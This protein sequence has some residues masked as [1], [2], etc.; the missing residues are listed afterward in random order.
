VCDS[1]TKT[2]NVVS[3]GS[4]SSEVTLDGPIW[5]ITLGVCG[6]FGSVLLDSFLVAET[7]SFVGHTVELDVEAS[8]SMKSSILDL[9]V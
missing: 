3:G 8:V 2:E 1:P 4:R 6:H 7:T 5:Y 9:G